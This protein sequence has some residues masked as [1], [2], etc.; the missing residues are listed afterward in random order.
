MPLH[1]HPVVLSPDKIK[2]IQRWLS[3]TGAR[4][5]VDFLCLKDA[6]H[7]AEA[8]NAACKALDTD[9]EAPTVQEHA[10]EAARCRNVVEMM[11]QMRDPDFKFKYRE[12]MKQT[13]TTQ[14][15]EE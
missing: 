14:P 2:E 11:A 13:A 10:R 1:L 9:G 15:D 4:A 5:F 12:P 3:E 7:T 6:E 8:G